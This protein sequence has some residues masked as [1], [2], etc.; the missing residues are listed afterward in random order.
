MKFR[1]YLACKDGVPLA[2]KEILEGR[3]GVGELLIED[4]PEPLRRRFSRVARFR[5]YDVEKRE[6]RRP[7]FDPV[8]VD[9]GERHIELSGFEYSKQ[10]DRPSYQMQRW[11][12]IA[13]GDGALTDWPPEISRR[14]ITLAV[15]P[16]PNRPRGAAAEGA[17]TWMDEH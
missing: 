3:S 16:E 2:G 11:I 9:I 7:L 13:P 10:D 1:L 6:A 12:L 4:V 8:L 17:A 5:R 15:P 14:R